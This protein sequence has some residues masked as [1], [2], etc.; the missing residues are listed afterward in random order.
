[1]YSSDRSFSFVL[2]LNFFTVL[3]PYSTRL[4]SY[5]LRP[6]IRPRLREREISP[7]FK[8]YPRCLPTYIDT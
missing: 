1:M 8:Y 7:Y 2:S 4:S 5:H 3:K 6:Y